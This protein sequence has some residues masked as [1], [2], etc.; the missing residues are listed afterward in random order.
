MRKPPIKP[1]NEGAFVKHAAFMMDDGFK[2]IAAS[3]MGVPY[4]SQIP[5]SATAWIE[6][7]VLE[8][9]VYKHS[10]QDVN[11]ATYTFK[12]GELIS[13]RADTPPMY[14]MPDRSKLLI[15]RIYTKGHVF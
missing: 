6:Y 13:L 4:K 9:F 5:F 1:F 2:A 8:D 14:F 15:N 12:H 3:L 10:G 11:N 7:L